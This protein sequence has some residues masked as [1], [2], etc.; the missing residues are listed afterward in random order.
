MIRAVRLAELTE[1]DR[2]ARWL[3]ERIWPREVPG[4][5]L[6]STGWAK[7]AA[8]SEELW[9]W[10]GEDPKRWAE[11][12]SRY[13]A[14]L[15]AN[16]AGWQPL[17]DVARGSELLLL[18]DAGDREHNNAVVLRDYL[19]A[20]LPLVRGADEGGESPCWLDRVCPECG[21]LID[22]STAASCSTCRL[23]G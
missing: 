6:R 17:R 9:R 15:D 7:A 13:V 19:L 14:E 12:R 2:G 23:P 11:F 21:R 22:D 8:P 18:Y 20:R 16:E 3:V 4:D 5:S 1:G 10:F